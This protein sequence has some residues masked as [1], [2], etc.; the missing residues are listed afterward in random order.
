MAEKNPFPDEGNTGHIWDDDIRELDH[1]PPRWWMISFYASI[2]FCIGYGIL[3][4]FWPSFSED[5]THTKGILGWTAVKEMQEDGADIDAVR[6]EFESQLVGKSAKDILTDD[7]LS[8]YAIRSAK[9]IFGD[10]CAPCHGNGGQ[11]GPSYPV[12]ADDDWLYG[13]TIET[14]VQ[15]IT[16]GRKGVMPAHA[17]SL[18]SEEVETLSNYTV[19][20]SNGTADAAGQAMFLGKGC[21]GCHGMNAKG[22]QVLGAANLSDAIWRFNEEDQFESAKYT[23]MHGVNF[24]ADKQSREAEMPNFSEKLTADEIKKLAVF[25]HKLGG[26]Q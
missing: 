11:G 6:A 7:G 10:F 17:S 14:I 9:V 24:V 13:G 25:V 19:N 1:P 20:L 4:P 22:L 8:D 2:A 15:S 5:G 26:G 21:V 3:Y 18:S 16:N 23:I 12:L